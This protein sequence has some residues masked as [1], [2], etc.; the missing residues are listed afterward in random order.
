ME[1]AASQGSGKSPTDFPDNSISAE[2][3]DQISNEMVHAV[4]NLPR[5]CVPCGCYQ[6][7]EPFTQCIYLRL[8]KRT[9]S[10]AVTD[11]ANDVVPGRL[12]ARL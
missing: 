5:L 4:T 6:C 2:W 10:S 8:K 9:N 1:I 3:L 11:I 12:K 7:T